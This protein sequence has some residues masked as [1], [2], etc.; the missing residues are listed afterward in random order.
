[1]YPRDNIFN[2]Y[3]EIGKRVPF[4]VKRSPWG[5]KGSN[6]VEYRYSQEGVTYMVERVI[7][8]GKYGYAFGYLM[9]NGVRDDELHKQYN[10]GKSN[11]S[12]PCAG[13]GEWCL[14][15]IPGMSKEEVEKYQDAK[16][17]CHATYKQT[18]DPYPTLRIIELYDVMPF[19]KYK[20]KTLREVVEADQSYIDWV[21]NNVK[22]YQLKLS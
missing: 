20:G 1:M 4:Q 18:G 13:C 7:P 19:G 15:D 8:K 10:Y 14:I 12:I 9:M 21:V 11:G 6:N 2:I 5:F 3:F 16:D 22:E 17:F